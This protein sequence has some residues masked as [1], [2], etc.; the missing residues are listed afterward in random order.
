MIFS[1]FTPLTAYAADEAAASELIKNY[2]AIGGNLEGWILD[3]ESGTI[4]AFTRGNDKLVILNAEDLSIKKE[5]TL[6]GVTDIEVAD[7]KLYA[8]QES[9]K[10]ICVID[11]KTFDVSYLLLQEKPHKI[12]V[13]EQKLYY[14]LRYDA[15]VQK[16]Y[17]QLYIVSINGNSEYAIT[18]NPDAGIQKGLTGDYYLTDIAADRSNH[19]LYVADSNGSSNGIFKLDADYKTLTTNNG[20]VLNGVFRDIVLSGS[21]VYYGKCRLDGYDLSQVYGSYDGVVSYA[22]GN[23]VFVAGE[24]IFDRVTFEK[25][26]E[27]PNDGSYSNFLEDGQGSV[28]LYE[29]QSY[30][31]FKGDINQFLYE[32]PQNADLTDYNADTATADNLASRLS[33]SK[34]LVDEDAGMIYALSNEKNALLFIGLSD[35]KLQKQIP[36]GRDP[37]DL[38]LAD[39]K[40]YVSLFSDMKI[41]V[42]DLKTRTVQKDLM[43]D[44]N[45]PYALAVDGDKLFFTG[46][47]NPSDYNLAYISGL[48]GDLYVYNLKTGGIEN[49]TGTYDTYHIAEKG[50]SGFSRSNMVLDRENHVLYVADTGNSGVCA[51]RTTDYQVQGVAGTGLH[52]Q[53]ERGTVTMDGDNLFYNLYKLEPGSLDAVY[54][55]CAESIVYTSGGF[56]FSKDAVYSAD[57]FEKVCDLPFESDSIYM[58]GQKNVY[59][60]D[61]SDHTI[62]KYSLLPSLD[63]FDERY[64]ALIKGTDYNL[65]D[66]QSE[67][68]Y[69]RRDSLKKLVVDDA[70]GRIYAITDDS[71]KLIVFG[72]DLKEQKELAIGLEPSD[73]ELYKGKLYISVTGSHYIMVIDPDTLS[74]T[75]K[76]RVDGQPELL[77]IDDRWIFYNDFTTKLHA[78]DRVLKTDTK[79]SFYDYQYNWDLTYISNLALDRENHVLYTVYGSSNDL[80]ENSVYA[81]DTKT[82]KPVEV[83]VAEADMPDTVQSDGNPLFYDNLLLYQ[84]IYNRYDLSTVLGDEASGAFLYADDQVIISQTHVYSQKDFKMLGDLS[85]QYKTLYTDG[86]NTVYTLGYYRHSIQKTSIRDILESAANKTAELDA[87]IASYGADNSTGTLKNTPPDMSG[88]GKDVGPVPEFSDVATH[89]AKPEIEEMAAKGI[90]TGYQ[91]RFSPD[92]NVTRA[93]FIAMLTRA[94]GVDGSDYYGAAF[95]DVPENAWYY[96][97]VMAGAALGLTNGSGNN[98]F[99]PD[100]PITREQIVTMTVRAMKYVNG[101]FE[102]ADTGALNQFTD[103]DSIS[104]WAKVDIAAAV[105]AGIVNGKSADRLDP[106]SD[107]T[108][109]ESAV[110][111]KRLLDDLDR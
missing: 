97:S 7:G 3:E 72:E 52:M 75:D 66:L 48:Q 106:K 73:I 53:N 49:L 104:D 64:D 62:K 59:I 87:I 110:I 94:L 108:R 95:N 65:D 1:L 32:A 19:T 51:I 41:S 14:I 10:T 45:M 67:V 2:G 88:A 25:T 83:P 69:G 34:W 81:I 6:S 35:L 100:K 74:V 93:E 23:N 11:L 44:K 103:R 70:R 98:S 38:A 40:L 42:V 63:G 61:G 39:G 27:F 101:D 96:S 28:Y 90:V 56:A 77:E 85:L 9:R 15:S 89:W 58:D 46:F 18:P 76:I 26:G 55:Y 84:S 37:E 78:Y 30:S 47:G 13:D 36:I 57:N 80:I 50:V 24:G 99:E 20:G 16:D 29:G 4:C 22:S 33:I 43:L 105:K 102:N 92:D 111:L 91:N 109:A 82:L 71:Y 12:A 79:I 8:A 68:P 54:G 31:V 21:D 107:T 86:G 60:Y 17:K 5:M